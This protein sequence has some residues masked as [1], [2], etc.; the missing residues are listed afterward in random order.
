MMP[1]VILVAVY[2]AALVMVL[3]KGTDPTTTAAIAVVLILQIV[4]T[5]LYA[6]TLFRHQKLLEW[7]RN[8]IRLERDRLPDDAPADLVGEE[9]DEVDD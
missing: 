2:V 4:A 1:H 7:F 5:I 8:H 6:D 3:L 9:D